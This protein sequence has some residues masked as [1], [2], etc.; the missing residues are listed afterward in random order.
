[1][2]VVLVK[3]GVPYADI[4][5]GRVIGFEMVGC[6]PTDS[7]LRSV[8]IISRVSITLYPL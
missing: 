3:M 8:T 5:K 6:I 7:N 2:F 4:Q 1:M